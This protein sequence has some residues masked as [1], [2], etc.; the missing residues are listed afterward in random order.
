MEWWALAMKNILAHNLYFSQRYISTCSPVSSLLS[1]MMSETCKSKEFLRDADGFKKR[2]SV[3]RLL[4]N[5]HV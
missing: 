5:C 4:E 1:N 2:N 3:N